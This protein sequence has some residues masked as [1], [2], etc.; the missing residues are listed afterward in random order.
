MPQ[1]STCRHVLANGAL[2]QAASLRDREYCRFHLQQIGRRMR[3]ARMRAR[4]QAP[5]L[6]LPL[7][8]DLYSVQVALMQLAD[9]IAHREIDPQSA[10]LLTTVLRLSMQNLKSKQWDHPS[11]FQLTDT[12]STAWDAFEQEHDLPAD[13]DLNLDPDVAFPQTA[14]QPTGAPLNPSVGL[15]GNDNA[16][17]S[18]VSQVLNQIHDAP[19]ARVSADQVELMEVYEQEGEQAMLK[20]ASQQLRNQ[21]RRERRV[22]RAFYDEVARKHNISAEA[23]RLIAEQ[24]K[25]PLQEAASPRVSIADQV[26]EVEAAFTR[27]PPHRHAAPPPQK[28]AK[29]EG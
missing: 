11:R 19:P 21:A 29:S 20:L 25:H 22:R 9:A 7:L 24:G 6:R 2:C 3:A 1:L 18:K 4:H 17:R 23:H 8:E 14:N 5:L 27:K 12:T 16:L 15:S 28:V 26:A 10:R 13:L